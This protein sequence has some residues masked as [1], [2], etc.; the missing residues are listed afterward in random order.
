MAV[1]QYF[2]RARCELETSPRDAE[3]VYVPAAAHQCDKAA[4]FAGPTPV[5]S[6]S[7]RMSTAL[8]CIEPLTGRDA[9]TLFDEAYGLKANPQIASVRIL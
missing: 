3:Q 4:L 5:M 9:S 7:K 6:K 1:R 2:I 8:C